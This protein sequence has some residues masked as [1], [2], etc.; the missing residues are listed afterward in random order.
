M[1]TKSAA[2]RHLRNP[3]GRP[4]KF[5]EPSHPITITLPDRMLNL[6]DAAGPDRARALARA[7]DQMYGGPQRTRPSVEVL[8][9]AKGVGIIVV[10]P[11]I[12]LR[13]IPKLRLV[14]VG[15]F[16][17][18][19]TLLGGL[20]AADLEVILADI[21]H[22]EERLDPGERDL[23]AALHQQLRNL[24]RNEQVSRAEILFVSI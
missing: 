5:K 1:K 16:R 13:K 6:L 20:V 23:I 24:R 22:E 4:R 11:S 8:E 7:V 2:S 9:V 21:L 12:R 14:E 15:P 19:L 17:Y 18:L 3:G 10:G